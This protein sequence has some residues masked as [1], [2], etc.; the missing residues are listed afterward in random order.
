MKK[1]LLVILLLAGLGMCASPKAQAGVFIGIGLPVLP[2]C[3]AYYPG[4][5]G[6][7]PYY[8]GRPYA[9]GC[10]GYYGYGHVYNGRYARGRVAHPSHAGHSDK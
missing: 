7:Y 5:Y 9:Y 10:R 6:P 4:Y 1:L 8:Y 3:P 2:V